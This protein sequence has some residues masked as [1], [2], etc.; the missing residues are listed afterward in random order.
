[1]HG[2]RQ[3]FNKELLQIGINQICMIL[4]NSARI[5]IVVRDNRRT[6]SKCLDIYI[7]ERFLDCHV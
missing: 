5:F 2:L 4:K 6:A 3:C 1:M 7:S